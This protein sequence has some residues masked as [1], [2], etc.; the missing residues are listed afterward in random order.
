MTKRNKLLFLSIV[1]GSVLVIGL[2]S[3]HKMRTLSSKAKDHFCEEM[4]FA[5]MNDSTKVFV[6]PFATDSGYVVVLP[7]YWNPS[8]ILARYDSKFVN[9]LDFS[10]KDYN[11]TWQQIDLKIGEPYTIEFSRSLLG[12]K[13]R[14]Q[15][16]FY[17]SKLNTI[18]LNTESGSIAKVDQSKDKSFS[19]RGQLMAITKLG[20][21]DY[22]GTLESIHG[23]GNSTWT[24]KKKPYSIKISHKACI[25]GLKRAKKFNLLANA[26]DESSLRNWIMFHTAELL[27]IPYSIHAEFT[28]LYINGHYKGLYQITNKV[29]IDESG[30]DI[31]DLG[32][33]TK[34]INSFAGKNLKDFPHFSINRNDTI[35]FKK[36]IKNAE[37]PEDITGGYLLDTNSKLHRYADCISGFIP[38]YGYPMEI[39]APEFATQEQVDYISNY[40]DEMLEAIR[41]EDGIN[42]KTGKQ[43]GEY[44]DINSYIKYYLCSELFYNYDAVF[45]S[46]IMYKDKRG[47]M[48]CGPMW[49]N[50]ISLNTKTRFD[51]A[52]GYNSLF[53]REAREKDGS[54]MIFG[55]LYKHPEYKQELVKIFNQKFLP[56]IKTYTE[57]NT[58]DS[59]HSLIAEDLRYNDLCW[60][61]AYYWTYKSLNGNT[62]WNDNAQKEYSE[63]EK[64]GDYWNVKTFLQ[65]RIDFMSKIWATNDSEKDFKTILW[66]FNRPNPYLFQTDIVSFL[67]KDE[68]FKWPRFMIKND[69]VEFV[70][71][72]DKSGNPIKE[73]EVRDYMKVV[74]EPIETQSK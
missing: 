9:S 51:A 11:S 73:G 18:F 67:I 3:I 46:F 54:L 74:Y 19:E 48:F 53:V 13:Q 35:G 21:I 65:K 56:I 68:E 71:V 31:S 12:N 69:K 27:E 50:D 59:I 57:G 34:I 60:P 26:F 40:M 37:N 49:D 55:Q 38:K 36:G 42:P 58:L 16:T 64:R 41:A 14:I 43:Y 8:R 2:L 4:A 24:Q 15:L 32:K 66:D 1:L 62:V 25:F 30:V 20:E 10:G 22:L 5:L 6:R 70:N 47:K 29:D 17:Q 33:E 45:A 23:R 72:V 61:N 52:N 28:T 39:K 63:I 7:A 44:L